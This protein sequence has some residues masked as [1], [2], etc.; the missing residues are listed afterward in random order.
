VFFEVMGRPRV[1]RRASLTDAPSRL[2][3]AR[4]ALTW[5][6]RFSLFSR[7]GRKRPVVSRT[8]CNFSEAH[9]RTHAR[10]GQRSR[11]LRL[12][13]R[14]S[15]VQIA[16]AQPQTAESRSSRFRGLILWRDCPV[17]SARRVLAESRQPLSGCGSARGDTRA[18]S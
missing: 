17:Y 16:P 3:N 18:L 5:I 1:Q 14:T 11:L 4:L 12:T 9:E 8:H 13:T 15:E 10:P 7:I 6:A 2:V